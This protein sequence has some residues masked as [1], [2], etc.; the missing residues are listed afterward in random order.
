M[1]P[2]EASQRVGKGMEKAG[3]GREKSQAR[4]ISGMVPQELASA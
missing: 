2:G 1:L 4:V 3:Q